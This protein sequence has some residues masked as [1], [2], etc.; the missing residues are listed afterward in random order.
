M[1]VDFIQGKPGKISIQ[2]GNDT[3]DITRSVINSV[4]NLPIKTSF[5]NH[6]TDDEIRTM[7]REIGY[8]DSAASMSKLCRPFMRK[9]WSFFFD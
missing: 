3:F 5:D 9:E 2:F 7:L 8:T 6:A 4:L 1:V